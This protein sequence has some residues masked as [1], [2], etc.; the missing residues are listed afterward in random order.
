MQYILP[1]YGKRSGP[2]PSAQLTVSLWPL[3]S[4]QIS[5]RLVPPSGRAAEVLAVFSRLSWSAERDAGGRGGGASPEVTHR[6]DTGVCGGH[7]GGDP[8]GSTAVKGWP[9][10]WEIENA[11]P[12]RCIQVARVIF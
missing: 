1:A 3:D 9:Y 4:L 6:E 5:L 8:G 7:T 10:R 12:L 11:G 2:G